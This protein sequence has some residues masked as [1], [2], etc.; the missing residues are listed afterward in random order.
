[1]RFSLKKVLSEDFL[2]EFKSLYVKAG[3]NK[4]FDEYYAGIKRY[5]F[6]AFFLSLPPFILLHFL[7][8]KFHILLSL[9]LSLILA[10]VMGLLTFFFL[11]Y[12][13]GMRIKSRATSID[14]GLAYSVAFMSAL[15]AA[16]LSAVRI[17][18][19]AVKIEDNKDLREEMYLFLK[20]TRLGGLDVVTALS[21][22]AERSPSRFFSSLLEGLRQ[23][24]I[25]TGNLSSYLAFMV[26]RLIDDKRRALGEIISGLGFLSEIY[27][28]LMVAAPV[29]FSILLSLMSMLGGKVFGL[30]PLL[31]LLFFTIA[32]IPLFSIAMIIVI[33]AWFSRV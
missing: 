11:T 9:T 21:V 16:G 5:P 29:M 7:V 23:T 30:D 19:E 31:L 27:I 17:F 8:L 22:A 33:D 6:I 13:P 25:T 24:M 1:M 32:L 3:I 18:E 20:D 12:Y 4:P 26:E 2:K 10:A 14:A 15:A 28:T